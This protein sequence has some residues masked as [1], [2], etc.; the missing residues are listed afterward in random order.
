[1]N[2]KEKIQ[3]YLDSNNIAKQDLSMTIRLFLNLL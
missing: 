1:M 3:Q 2:M